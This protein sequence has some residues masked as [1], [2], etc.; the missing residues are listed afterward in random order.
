MESQNES[1]PQSG[2]EQTKDT[3]KIDRSESGRSVE[4]ETSRFEY[5]HFSDA[6]PY[7]AD[8]ISA[9]RSETA[10]LFKHV[11]AEPAGFENATGEQLRNLQS[12]AIERSK[13]RET[14]QDGFIGIL[15]LGRR[16]PSR[17]KRIL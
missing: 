6:D 8:R 16:T 5:E 15:R 9:L 7:G 14:R 12:D 17:A 10:E 2:N 13:W 3:S 1:D 4:L 11:Q